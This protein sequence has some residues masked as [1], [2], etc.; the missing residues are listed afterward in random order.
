MNSLNN[1]LKNENVFSDNL[2]PI[3]EEIKK[4]YPTKK[5]IFK[6]NIEKDLL[7]QS[8]LIY[9]NLKTGEEYSDVF[10]SYITFHQIYFHLKNYFFIKRRQDKPYKL[11]FADIFQEIFSD[12]YVIFKEMTKYLNKHFL[13]YMNIWL[14]GFFI[15]TFKKLKEDKTDFKYRDIEPELFFLIILFLALPKISDAFNEISFIH[16]INFSDKT[17]KD[18][19]NAINLFDNIDL[20]NFDNQTY[21][22]KVKDF[23]FNF[24]GLYTRIDKEGYFYF[25]DEQKVKCVNFLNMLSDKTTDFINKIVEL[26][27]FI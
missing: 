22:N 1:Q 6:E 23:I 14:D 7:P 17:E 8:E 18:W 3:Y 5:Y 10:Y 19:E 24:F 4:K 12:N 21:L 13:F 16:I 25:S 26:R 11:E 20:I 27:G 2:E 15:N 9:E